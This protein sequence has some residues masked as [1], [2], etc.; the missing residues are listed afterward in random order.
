MS[1]KIVENIKNQANSDYRIH[2]SGIVC[3]IFA[4]NQI[5]G[6]ASTLTVAPVGFSLPQNAT[7]NQKRYSVIAVGSAGVYGYPSN[8]MD[9]YYA[10][11]LTDNI[12]KIEGKPAVLIPKSVLLSNPGSDYVSEP[13]IIGADDVNAMVVRKENLIVSRKLS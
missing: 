13:N 2:V 5:N 10:Y 12:S 4:A 11:V 8:L 3:D 6:M 7:P 1:R 9:S